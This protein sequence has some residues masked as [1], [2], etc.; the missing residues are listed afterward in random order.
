MI[1][2]STSPR[3][4]S[5]I[6]RKS[7]TSYDGVPSGRRAWMWIIAPPSS[8]IRRASAAYSCGVYGIA[9][10][11]SRL[12][13]APEIAHVMMTGS[14]RLMSETRAKSRTR[15][16]SLCRAPRPR[17]NAQ[18]RC[19]RQAP[20]GAV[21]GRAPARER[22]RD[23]P[24][25]CERRLEHLVE[26]QRPGADDLDERRVPQQLGARVEALAHRQPDRGDAQAERARDGAD[27][28]EQ[29]RRVAPVELMPGD[30]QDGR[31]DDRHERDEAGPAAAIGAH[32]P[33]DHRLA[34]L[35]AGVVADERLGLLVAGHELKPDHD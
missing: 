1:T 3:I 7:S 12:A 23:L 15:Y 2:S 21:P 30:E 8:T 34:D 32:H 28:R 25:A 16:C 33:R 18:A 6:A 31:R 9:G 27:E 17:S 4:A 11:C 26:P 19:C 22:E 29:P 24:A 14:S 13:S 20:H 35:R 10:H 5:V